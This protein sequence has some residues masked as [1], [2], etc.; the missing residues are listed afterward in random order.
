[1]LDTGNNV[2]MLQESNGTQQCEHTEYKALEA[3][4]TTTTVL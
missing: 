2:R 3:V 4:H 1:M